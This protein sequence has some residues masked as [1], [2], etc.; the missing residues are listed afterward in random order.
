MEAAKGG[1]VVSLHKLARQLGGMVGYELRMQWRRRGLLAVTIVLAAALLLVQVWCAQLTRRV[2][3]EL[4]VPLDSVPDEAFLGQATLGLYYGWPVALLLM[5]LAVPP[6]V[7]DT[8][9]R[10]RQVAVRELL[11][12]LPL[13]RGTYLAGKLLGAWAGVTAGLVGV[14]LFTGLTA[15]LLFGPFYLD[16]YLALW[17]VGVG[18]LALFTS[19]MS[20]LLASGQPTRRRAVLVS[21]GF[22][23]CCVAMLL[24]TTGTV[25]DAISLARPSVFLA[26]QSRYVP[27]LRAFVEMG[28]YGYPPAQISLTVGGGA[29]QVALAWL[30]AWAWMHW[31]E[32]VR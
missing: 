9:P 4:E 11:D 14:A 28:L 16:A 18:P 6:V 12:S 29:L 2:V 10:D 25:R 23:V 13:D 30:G 20:I 27:T 19:G 1:Q 24:T 5:T 22:A 32:R 17:A 15:W 3:D 26:L 21:I 7:A 31:K 8:I